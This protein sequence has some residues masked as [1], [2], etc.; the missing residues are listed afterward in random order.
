MLYTP[1]PC[2]RRSKGV[3]LSVV[4][5]TFAACAVSPSPTAISWLSFA[6]PELDGER[7]VKERSTAQA[8]HGHQAVKANMFFSVT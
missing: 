5:L 8:W 1:S 7:H 3:L 2:L 4:G 6:E